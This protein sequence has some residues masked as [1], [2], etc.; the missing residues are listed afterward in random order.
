MI[1]WKQLSPYLVV[2]TTGNPLCVDLRIKSART[3]TCVCN[4]Y[5]QL[6]I[7]VWNKVFQ[8]GLNLASRNGI[9][10]KMKEPQLQRPFTTLYCNDWRSHDVFGTEQF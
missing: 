1:P 7:L 5:G 9:Y 4:M 6:H 8:M 10:S 2:L 3:K